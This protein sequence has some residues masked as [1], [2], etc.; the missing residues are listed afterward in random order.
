MIP[1]EVSHRYQEQ[2]GAFVLGKLEGA[3]LEAMQTHL[4]GCHDCLAEVRELQPVVAALADADPDRIDEYPR[5]PSGL[6]ES[7]LAPICFW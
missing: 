4:N 2:I 6:E 3:E 1:P 5:P 7:S